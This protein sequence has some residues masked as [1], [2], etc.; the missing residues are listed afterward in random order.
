MK[1]F[2]V[3]LFEKGSIDENSLMRAAA[4]ARTHADAQIFV[5]DL[6]IPDGVEI[7]S[8]VTF[9]FGVPCPK[10]SGSGTAGKASYP[11]EKGS[12]PNEK[13]EALKTDVRIEPLRFHGNAE[14]ADA[15]RKRV[16]MVEEK[17]KAEALADSNKWFD[18][19]VKESKAELQI[20]DVQF[21]LADFSMDL[22]VGWQDEIEDAFGTYYPVPATAR[23][24]ARLVTILEECEVAFAQYDAG[25]FPDGF[26]SAIARI[27]Q[28]S[29]DL[30]ATTDEF[31]RLHATD[32]VASLL[33]PHCNCTLSTWDLNDASGVL[34]TPPL[35]GC[36]LHSNELHEYVFQG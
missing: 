5:R 6:D 30:K 35:S 29:A 2:T 19:L 16:A 11:N 9:V 22:P 26:D 34:I 4:Q 33:D 23:L 14:D 20:N 1:T 21:K 31:E 28:L 8:G 25:M 3:C 15:Y 7:P 13:V 32:V 12:Y 18:D 17:A 24:A 10:N 36:P 27:A